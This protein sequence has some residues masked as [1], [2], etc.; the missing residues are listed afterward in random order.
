MILSPV[1]DQMKIISVLQIL[2]CT[3]LRPAITDM[4]R[5]KLNSLTFFSQ[6]IPFSTL[7][8]PEFCQHIFKVS[9]DNKTS[10]ISK[11]V[12]IIN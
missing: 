11:V 4:S 8:F 10:M 6:F 1:S 12:L 9:I 3:F 7:F 2:T 5:T